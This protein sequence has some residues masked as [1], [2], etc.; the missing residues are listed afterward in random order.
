MAKG[1]IT[2]AK[3]KTRPSKDPERRKDQLIN[4]AVDLAEKK[5]KDGTASSQLIVHY[6]K[7]EAERKKEAIELEILKNQKE[8]VAAKAEA[9]R[10]ASNSEELYSKAMDAI[11]DYRGHGKD[12]YD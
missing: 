6:L 5:L 12:E 7:L 4:L 3:P 8:L 2:P 1:K 11:R 9:Y 10:S